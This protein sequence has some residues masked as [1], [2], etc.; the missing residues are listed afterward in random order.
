[1][2]HIRNHRYSGNNE[3]IFSMDTGERIVS[4]RS[5]REH[6]SKALQEQER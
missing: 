4:G 3:Y 5:Y 6:I 2:A 1:M